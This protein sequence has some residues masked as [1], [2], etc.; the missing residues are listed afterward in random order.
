MPGI[1]DEPVSSGYLQITDFTRDT[2]FIYTISA[3]TIQRP[4]DI[5]LNVVN[6][7]GVGAPPQQDDLIEASYWPPELPN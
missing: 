6:I 3:T 1:F 4:T 2:L 5:L 7:E